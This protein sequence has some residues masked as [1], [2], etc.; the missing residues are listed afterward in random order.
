MALTVAWDATVAVRA[1]LRTPIDFIESFLKEKREWIEKTLAK[2]R[3]RAR[4]R[5]WRYEDGEMFWYLGERY[6]LRVSERAISPLIFSKGEFVMAR[7]FHSRAKEA[8]SWWYIREA[9]RIL[10]ERVRFFARENKLAY[11]TVKINAAR[12]RWGSCS[13]KGNLNFSFRLAM[14]PLSVIDSVVVHELAHLVHRNH[15]RNFW[16]KAASMLPEFEV[17]RHWLKKNGHLLEC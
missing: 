1:P 2:V 3:E 9:K 5:E 17:G 4:E 10:S 6:P 8:F 12:T 16:Q 13:G 15:S 14:A 7:S 11:G